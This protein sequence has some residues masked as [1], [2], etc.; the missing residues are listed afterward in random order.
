MSE[1]IAKAEDPSVVSTVV[2]PVNEM[3]DALE[4]TGVESIT[5]SIN[6]MQ[7]VALT[8]KPRLPLDPDESI[9]TE[10][11]SV[12]A[13]PMQEKKKSGKISGWFIKGAPVEASWWLN[14]PLM[15]TAT[16]LFESDT[17]RTQMTPLCSTQ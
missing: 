11:K 13:S 4:A 7:P 15:K 16:K 3:V 1:S 8:P 5:N 2:V 9:N 17:L 6:A 14:Y 10:N 12:N